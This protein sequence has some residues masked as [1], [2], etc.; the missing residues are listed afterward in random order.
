[1]EKKL[2]KSCKSDLETKAQKNR[3]LMPHTAAMID[4]LR[5]EFGDIKVLYAEEGDYRIG[6]PLDRSKL[7]KPVIQEGI[8]PKERKKK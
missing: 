6:K 4:E 8:P 1:M 5:S 3:K 7:V 2:P